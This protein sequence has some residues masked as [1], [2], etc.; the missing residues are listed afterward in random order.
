[1]QNPSWLIDARAWLDNETSVARAQG[2]AAFEV[3]DP[4]EARAALDALE[5]L[6]EIRRLLDSVG[7]LLGLENQTLESDQP[8]PPTGL[9]EAIPSEV[10][11][12][13]TPDEALPPSDES[14][15]PSEIG[16]AHSGALLPQ[17]ADSSP[18]VDLTGEPAREPEPLALDA[19]ESPAPSSAQEAVGPAHES[20]VPSVPT[21][22]TNGVAVAVPKPPAKSQKKA[23]SD[24]EVPTF[25]EV[26]KRL[27]DLE[28]LPSWSR[29]DE[30]TAKALV[31]D[32]RA[33][34]AAGLSPDEKHWY[35]EE[36]KLLSELF[37]QHA[38]RQDFFGFSQSRRPGVSAW[39]A[40]GEAYR[41]MAEAENAY[42]WLADNSC[43]EKDELALY[44]LSAAAESLVRRIIE[45]HYVDAGD[46]QQKDLHDRLVMH[47]KDQVVKVWL[48]NGTQRLSDANTRKLALDLPVRFGD[49]VE[50]FG[51]GQIKQAALESLDQVL[52]DEDV[53]DFETRLVSA[54]ERVLDAK[55]P[56]SDKSLR[57]KLMPYR[58]FLGALNSKLGKKLLGYVVD[59]F[60]KQS[61]KIEESE[62][63]V[64]DEAEK[65]ETEI[66]PDVLTF[67]KGK[68]FMLVGGNKGQEKRK[69]VY[70][71]RLG[72][73]DVIWP[74]L[75]WDSNPDTVT[76]LL[77]KADIVAFSI[78][79]SRHCYKRIIDEAKAQGKAFVI[80]KAGLSSA[81]VANALLTQV[82][83]PQART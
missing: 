10:P 65:N 28:D 5:R 4:V 78:R 18:P 33:V 80:L 35:K 13:E 58:H 21:A 50:R 72:F 1:M 2:I 83:S 3:A 73:S 20:V 46:E 74:D 30:A 60:N 76:H 70:K 61:S 44:E 22:L 57:T 69:D 79:F 31:C 68:T 34:E 16:A 36:L 37:G 19:T 41:L 9:P 49:V 14:A 42:A 53:E 29:A 32:F 38:A 52:G 75:E 39:L 40:L 54:V 25:P 12:P 45:S 7:D 48:P 63:E 17:P 11:S 71:K 27:R 43:S 62:V 51:K 67:T 82:V 59:D 23:L 24:R 64:E 66:H 56:P 77:K 47:L 81:Q 8:G 15:A 6:I 26:C 55:V